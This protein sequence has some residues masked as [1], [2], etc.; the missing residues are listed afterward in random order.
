MPSEVDRTIFTLPFNG[1]EQDVD[2]MLQLYDDPE[3][4]FFED[5]STQKEDKS[6]QISTQKDS[7]NTD[8]SKV[9]TQKSTQIDNNHIDSTQK[10][11]QKRILETLQTNPKASRSELAKI[12][13]ITEDGIKKQLAKLKEIGKIERIGPDRGGYWNV[14]E[15]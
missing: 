3:E 11:T 4:L 5:I 15:G 10:S 8:N 9:S 12:I 6:T 1:H 2:A 13:G 14:I 7:D